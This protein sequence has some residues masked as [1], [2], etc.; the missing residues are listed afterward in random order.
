MNISRKAEYAIRAMVDL[1]I[2]Y[3]QQPIL[4]KDIAKRQDIPQ[5]FLVQ[6]IPSLKS[7]G[8]VS[9]VRGAG[10]GIYLGK[11]PDEINIRQIIE[12]IEGPIALNHCLIGA[13]GCHRKPTCPIH[14]TWQSAQDK[15]LSVL[16]STTLSRVTDLNKKEQGRQPV[17]NIGKLG[18]EIEVEV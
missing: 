3:E 15:M 13:T 6:I 11:R 1:A 12:A 10:G 16:E 9:T 18:N 14:R 7:S 4:S 2:N 5:K 8:L 17:G